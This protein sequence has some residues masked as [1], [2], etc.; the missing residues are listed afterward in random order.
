L[1]I[2]V[3]LAIARRRPK[4]A[5]TSLTVGSSGTAAIHT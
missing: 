1:R 3:G 2:E 4:C 5:S